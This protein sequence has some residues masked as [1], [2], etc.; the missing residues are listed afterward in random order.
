MSF[1]STTDKCKKRWC[2]VSF[3]RRRTCPKEKRFA[4]SFF[5]VPICTRS[6]DIQEKNKFVSRTVSLTWSWP[7]IVLQML[8]RAFANEKLR[9]ISTSVT[10]LGVTTGTAEF[11]LRLLFPA[12]VEGKPAKNWLH[13]SLTNG[14]GDVAPR[15]MILFVNIL[16]QRARGDRS[17]VPVFSETELVAAMR[18]VSESAFEEV[19]NDF[20]VAVGFVRSCKSGKISVFRTKDV[21]N[22][23]DTSDGP[24]NVQIDLLERLGFLAREIVMDNGIAVPRFSVPRLYS[25]C[26]LFS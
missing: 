26:W 15:Q 11:H 4:L 18:D 1:T 16:K 13:E 25:R 6:N 2:K 9:M 10:N 3:W 7:Q 12:A 14:R 19:V 24:I 21:E 5:F 17:H 22:L 8:G 23:F 20:R